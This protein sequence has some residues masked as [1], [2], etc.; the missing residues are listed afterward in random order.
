MAIK[1]LKSSYRVTV[2]STEPIQGTKRWR[3]SFKILK[4]AKL[5]EAESSVDVLKGRTPKLGAASKAQV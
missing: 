2:T 5:W 1:E 3:R 4:D